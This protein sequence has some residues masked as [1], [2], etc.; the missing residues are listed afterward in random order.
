VGSALPAAARRLKPAEAAEAARGLNQALAREKEVP[1][2]RLPWEIARARH[3]LAWAL[4]AVAGRLEPADAARAC[5]EAARL[6][7]QALAGGKD[8]F[9]RRQLADG[10][11]FV[12]PLMEPVEGAR[13]CLDAARLL[14]QALSQEGDRSDREGLAE[15]L[16]AVAAVA[17]RW[18]PAATARVL[19]QALTQE[20]NARARERLST[21]LAEVAGRLQP[22]EA[23][24]A[25][26]ESARLLHKALLRESSPDSRVIMVTGLAALASRLE[27]AEAA[28]LLNQARAET[29]GDNSIT[30]D[31]HGRASSVRGELAGGLARVAGRMEPAAA[32]LLLREA[33]A[34]EKD[35]P[36]R[37]QLAE[38]LAVVEGRLEPAAAARA[39]AEAVRLDISTFENAS[40]AAGRHEAAERLSILLEPLDE[41][42]GLHAAQVS[43][44]WLVSH[45]D[46]LFVDV[47]DGVGGTTRTFTPDVL[48]RCLTNRTHPHVRRRAAAV[49][50]AVGTS[51]QGSAPG[52]PLLPAAAEPFPC[53]LSTQELVDLLKMPTC[54]REVRRFILDQLGNRYGRQFDTQ[55]DFVRYAGEKGL[56]LNFTTPPQRPESKVPPLFQ[57]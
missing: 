46:L 19:R 4:S 38:G 52:L 51:A 41:E 3:S 21:T 35:D 45:S 29:K 24:A 11:A 42:S 53:R 30:F 18:E 31:G 43:V 40:D 15:G 34:E 23:A 26:A 25:C 47:P 16:G 36:A 57:E 13:V 39:C 20:L 10:L 8:A 33:L 12:G 27:P 32:A 2:G 56:N 6:Q 9:S 49:A 5:G 44:R 7:S 14:N 54:V 37:R 17:G 50:A 48:E 22:A 28:R 55:W 1:G